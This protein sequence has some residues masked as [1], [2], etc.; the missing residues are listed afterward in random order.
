MPN[1]PLSRIAVNFEL[2]VNSERRPGEG[3]LASRK[4]DLRDDDVHHGTV[5]AKNL[6]TFVDA[7]RFGAVHRFGYPFEAMVQETNPDGTVVRAHALTML[8]GLYI[9]HD[10]RRIDAMTACRR[11]TALLGGSHC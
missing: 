1:R 9:D 3:L 8:P 10:G 2:A 11:F 5:D 6:P 7:T 4:I